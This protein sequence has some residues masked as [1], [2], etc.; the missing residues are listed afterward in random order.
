MMKWAERESA[1]FEHVVHL[2]FDI[3]FIISTS[4]NDGC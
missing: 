4:G 3:M 1:K 2:R